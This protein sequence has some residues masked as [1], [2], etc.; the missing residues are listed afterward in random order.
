MAEYTHLQIKSLYV[1]TGSSVGICFLQQE[2][3]I[4][5]IQ[6]KWHDINL[7]KRPPAPVWQL[8][9]YIIVGILKWKSAHSLLYGKIL[10]NRIV[11]T[12]DKRLNQ[13]LCGIDF[14]KIFKNIIV[15]GYGIKVCASNVFSSCP[16]TNHYLCNSSLMFSQVSVIVHRGSGVH[17]PGRHLIV[18]HPAKTPPRTPQEITLWQTP[19]KMATA[20]G[21]KHSTGYILLNVIFFLSSE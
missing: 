8:K 10:H 3:I 17:P 12:P 20:A 13:M 5:L 21:G 2:S 1:T 16:V 19:P 4:K 15:G 6:S 18:R 9:Y 11:F 14:F 7:R